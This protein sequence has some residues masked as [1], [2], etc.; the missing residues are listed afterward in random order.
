MTQLRFGLFVRLEDIGSTMAVRTPTETGPVYATLVTYCYAKDETHDSIY[1]YD[2]TSSRW[3]I[4][5][6]KLKTAIIAVSHVDIFSEIPQLMGLFQIHRKPSE[7]SHIMLRAELI[8][9][10]SLLIRKYPVD[11]LT[12]IVRNSDVQS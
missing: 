6:P 8:Q 11:P 4:H 9:G 5:M 7:G 3:T 10:V 12:R 2:R 1:T